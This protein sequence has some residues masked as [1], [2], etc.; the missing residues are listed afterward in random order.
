MKKIFLLI[1]AVSFLLAGAFFN[2]QNL[3]LPQVRAADLPAGGQSID[4]AAQIQAGNFSLGTLAAKEA[5][6][7]SIAVKAGQELTVSGSFVAQD[8]TY[9]NNN[10]IEIFNE[11][12]ESLV[13]DM[14][15]AGTQITVKILAS[16][17]KE[18]HTYYIKISDDTWGTA[19]GSIEIALKDSFDA[20]SKTDAADNFNQALSISAGKYNGFLSQVDTDDYYKISAGKGNFSVKI[21]PQDGAMQPTLKIYDSQKTALKE[22]TAESA[23]EVVSA[24]QNLDEASAVYISINCDINSGC[25]SAAS[26]YQMEISAEG[27]TLSNTFENTIEIQLNT[28]T[29]KSVHNKIYP[30]LKEV[31]EDKVKLK[32]Q[33]DITSLVYIVSRPI[34]DFDLRTLRESLEKAGYKTESSTSNQIIMKK[35]SE[36]L[37]FFLNIGDAEN[38]IIT[39]SVKKIINWKLWGPIGV[40]ILIIAI[41]IIVVIKRKKPSGAAEEKKE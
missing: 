14:E 20:G 21:T 1:F 40:G 15:S 9:G 2:F 4:G 5:R 13:N 25:G 23:G 17:S 24:S 38:P 6:Y 41:I 34:A 36:E 33:K 28:P 27:A 18:T 16:S 3:T 37:T 30:I 31:F 8:Q 10:T 39:V 7:F 11:N 22:A 32:E 19:S 26:E 12:K 35:G 29:L